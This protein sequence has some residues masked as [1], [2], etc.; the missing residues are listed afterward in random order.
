MG[1]VRESE[2]ALPLGEQKTAVCQRGG[3]A[4]WEDRSWDRK[5]FLS[6]DVKSRGHGEV[7]GT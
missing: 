4:H 1:L 2:A 3:Q 6:P 7:T 5:L